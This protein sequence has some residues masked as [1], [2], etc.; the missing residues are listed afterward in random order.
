MDNN[1]EMLK[2]AKQYMEQLA[3]GID[4]ISGIEIPGD[5]VLNNVRLSRCFF[6]VADVLRQT[7]EAGGKVAK[8]SKPKK[9][10]FHMTEEEKARVALSDEP[11]YISHFCERLNAEIDTDNVRKCPSSAFGKW[12]LDKGFLD[13]ETI[14]G[15]AHKKAS[16]LGESIGIVARPSTYSTGN[17]YMHT[18]NRE[19]QQ[20]LL[21]NLGE[22]IAFGRKK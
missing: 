11:L 9:L 3:N 4:P 14:D 7:I 19:A 12:L 5:A 13:I 6:Y 20:F 2:R 22:I 16:A 18:Y 17:A 1:L 8:E 15:T 21:D 10:P